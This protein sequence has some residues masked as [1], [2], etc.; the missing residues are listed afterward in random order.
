MYKTGLI[1]LTGGIGC[2]KSTTLEAFSLLSCDTLDADG[3]MRIEIEDYDY[4]RPEDVPNIIKHLETFK[5]NKG[6]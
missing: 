2:G 1:G 5:L 3:H 4:I 6:E